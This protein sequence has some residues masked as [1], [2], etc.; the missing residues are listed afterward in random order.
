[1]ITT[2]VFLK[3]INDGE[4]KEWVN[5]LKVLDDF[6]IAYDAGKVIQNSSIPAKTKVTFNKN[7]VI[8]NVQYNEYLSQSNTPVTTIF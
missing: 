6:A 5:L 1:M 8:T 2:V 3:N 4:N 7:D